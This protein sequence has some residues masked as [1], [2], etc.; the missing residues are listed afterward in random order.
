M[1]LLSH[2]LSGGTEGQ[3]SYSPIVTKNSEVQNELGRLAQKRLSQEE[4]V[5]RKLW[6]E[7]YKGLTEIHKFRMDV[8][9]CDRFLIK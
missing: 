1:P 4:P 6:N 2:T 8:F 5:R 7:L 9:L 3:F